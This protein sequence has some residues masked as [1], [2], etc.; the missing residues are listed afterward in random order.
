MVLKIDL[1]FFFG[2]FLLQEVKINNLEIELRI[3]LPD[4][5]ER[6]VK[7]EKN[8]RTKDVCEVKEEVKS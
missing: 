3:V 1:K 5:S 4:Q 8:S 6:P 7:V 2:L